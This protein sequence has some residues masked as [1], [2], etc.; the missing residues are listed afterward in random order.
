MQP[1]FLPYVGYFQL[2][3]AVDAFIVY[4]NIQFSRK[5]WVQRNRMLVDGKDVMFSIPLKKDSDFLNIDQRCLADSFPD[6]RDKTLRRINTAYHKAPYF[7]DAMPVIENCFY[8]DDKN[9][10]R[11]VFNSI[12]EISKYLNLNTK[13]IISSEIEKENNLKGKSRVIALCK[14]MN[15]ENYVNA[16]GGTIL[17]DKT[18]FMNH[19]VELN[20]LKTKDFSYEQFANEFVPYLSIL[21]LMMFNRVEKINEFLNMYELV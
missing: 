11:Y 13:L 9:L 12:R 16:I 3:N 7:N 6:E 1:Y 17:Y 2:I 5:G 18:D 8:Y 19:G 20:F 10:F 15:A 14:V 21:D 4:D